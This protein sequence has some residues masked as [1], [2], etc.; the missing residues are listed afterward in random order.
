MKTWSDPGAFYNGFHGYCAIFVN[1]S[2]A[3]A[4][5][6]LVGLAVAETDKP[7]IVMPMATKQVVWRLLIFY[8]VSLLV[9]GFIVPYTDPNLLGGGGANTSPFVIAADMAGISGMADF[10][11]AII[12]ISTLSVGNAAVYGG[13][14]A[15]LALVEAG[16]VSLATLHH[17]MLYCLFLLFYFVLCCLDLMYA[18]IYVCNYCDRLLRLWDMWTKVDDHWSP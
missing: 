10:M 1:A 17:I 12:L 15:I 4:G 13:S 8:V 7:H 2:F 5:T 16:Q 18:C 9:V 6:E 3:Y 11:N 14:R